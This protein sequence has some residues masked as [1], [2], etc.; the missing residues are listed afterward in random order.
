MTGGCP[1]SPESREAA[2]PCG[3]GRRHAS[4]WPP[5]AFCGGNAPA[6]AQRVRQAS[7]ENAA[8]AFGALAR[9]GSVRDERNRPRSCRSGP[10]VRHAD[11]STAW[12]SRSP[13]AEARAASSPLAP[14]PEQARVQPASPSQ[15]AGPAA[16]AD[17][18]AAARQAPGR[19]VRPSSLPATSPCWGSQAAPSAA[20][21]RR[22]V[23]G[24]GEGAVRIGGGAQARPRRGRGP[25]ITSAR[26]HEQRR[27]TRAPLRGTQTAVPPPTRPCSRGPRPRP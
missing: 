5:S 23:Q 11:S 12:V 17:C 10:P 9:C 8:F 16:R 26:L 27:F 1:R 19:P 3:G 4:S 15:K 7:G 24:E 22:P 18:P 13:K 25:D 14:R 21:R 2:A 20:G 6:L